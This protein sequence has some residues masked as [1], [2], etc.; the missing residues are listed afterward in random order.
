MPTLRMVLGFFVGLAGLVYGINAERMVRESAKKEAN[1]WN[2]VRKLEYQ[3]LN[4]RLEVQDCERRLYLQER[5]TAERLGALH[6]LRC[7]LAPGSCCS[8]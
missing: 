5:D 2:E 8:G 7:Q 4:V 3:L 1:A 6:A